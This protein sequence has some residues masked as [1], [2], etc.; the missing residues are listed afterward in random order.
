MPRSPRRLAA[1]LALL[2]GFAIAIAACSGAPS[3]PALTDPTEII[4]AALKATEFAKSVHVDVTVDGSISADLTGTGSPGAELPLTGTTAAADVDMAGGKAH[5]TFAIPA[6]LNLNGDLIQIGETSYVKTSLTGPLY[7]AQDATNS[8]PVDPADAS[9]MFDDV[10]D[11]LSA[12]GVDPVKGD[13]VDCGGK[14]C[15]TVSIELTSEELAALGGDAAAAAGLPVD[16]GAASVAFT[17]RVEKDTYRLAGLKTVAS[18][19]EMGSLTLDVTLTK[20]DQPLDISAP[21]ADQIKAA[22]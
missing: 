12:D 17:I 5:V 21:P 2:S 18:L 1:P 8:L 22:E 11:L 9:G 3:L 14:Q 4:T 20:W 10:G 16:L 13:D 7:E 19:G 6:I 15:Y